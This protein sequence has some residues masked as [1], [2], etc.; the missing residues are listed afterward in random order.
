MPTTKWTDELLDP[1]RKAGH[2]LADAAIEELYEPVQQDQVREALLLLDG[3]SEAVPAGLPPKLQEYFTR[4]A[5]L[6]DWA[7]P[8]LPTR[9]QGLLGRY[10]GH[11]GSTLLCGSLPLC[12][13]CAE[14]AA[15]GCPADT[16]QRKPYG[17]TLP[18]PPRAWAARWSICHSWP[19]PLLT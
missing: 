11:I 5:A 7:D 13:G 8:A 14:G 19:W 12:Y 17:T 16:P 4:S 2:P 10:Q 18:T 15:G 6:P 1:L 3:N 9:G